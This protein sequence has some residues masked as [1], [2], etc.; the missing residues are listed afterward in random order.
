MSRTGLSILLC[1]AATAGKRYR[2]LVFLWLNL[3]IDI[4]QIYIFLV[5]I[6][7]SQRLWKVWSE[8]SLSNSH[9]DR[10]K[11]DLFKTVNTK[12]VKHQLSPICLKVASIDIF[13]CFYNGHFLQP[14]SKI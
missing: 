13:F 4:M 2:Q 12:V 14:M 7:Y 9:I 6:S 10:T 8:L 11:S 3:A 5:C 1:T